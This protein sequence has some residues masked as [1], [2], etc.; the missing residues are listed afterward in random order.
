MSVVASFPTSAEI[1]QLSD[2]CFDEEM[3]ALIGQ[4]FDR[5]CAELPENQSIAVSREA[6]A[7]RVIHIVGRGERNPEKI[8]NETLISL[9]LKPNHFTISTMHHCS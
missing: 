6:V 3:T 4:T 1:V 9:G 5:I 2:R 7:K 8:C